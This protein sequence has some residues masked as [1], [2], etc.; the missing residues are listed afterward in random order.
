MCLIQ[1]RASGTESE[2]FDALAISNEFGIVAALPALRDNL[3]FPPTFGIRL[4]IVISASSQ[5]WRC[6]RSGMCSKPRPVNGEPR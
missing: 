6:S 2:R 5:G 4:P 1:A 3:K